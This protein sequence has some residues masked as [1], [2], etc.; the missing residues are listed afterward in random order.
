MSPG[1]RAVGRDHGLDVGRVA[2][3]GADDDVSCAL[4]EWLAAAGYTTASVSRVESVFDDLPSD[5]VVLN[6][7]QADGLL[8]SA[9]WVRARRGVRLAAV[10]PATRGRIDAA[11]LLDSGADLVLAPPLRRNEVVA[12]V[13]ALLR[14][15]PQR[16]ATEV[17]VRY[18]SL[19]LDRAGHRLHLGE[20]ALDLDLR[21]FGLLD[22]LLT[23]PGEVTSRASLCTSLALSETQLESLVR[24]T[25]KRL[26][27]V[28]GWRRI[29]A[30]RRVGVRL[31][32][33]APASDGSP[34]ER[35]AYRATG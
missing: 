13:R 12:R 10:L 25:R 21:E 15:A 7:S 23:R 9:R 3:V 24:R 31:L 22:A 35:T 5:L 33:E 17:A 34:S 28:E 27:A 16:T 19:L 6:A 4:Q 29:V 20:V 8:Q 18:G 11:H 26:E 2:V 32:A 30:Q 14:R 1:A